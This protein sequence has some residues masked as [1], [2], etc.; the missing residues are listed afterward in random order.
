MA[1]EWVHAELTDETPVLF[2]FVTTMGMRSDTELD[3]RQSNSTA[4]GCP[5]DT[6]PSR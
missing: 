4:L 6:Q 5:P 2:N 1:S 3:C